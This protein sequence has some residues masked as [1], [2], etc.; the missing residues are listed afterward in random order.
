[1][2]N[3][4]SDILIELSGSFIF[5]IVTIFSLMANSRANLGQHVTAMIIVFCWIALL[6]LCKSSPSVTF[7]PALTLARFLTGREK[8]GRTAALIGVQTGGSLLAALLSRFFIRKLAPLRFSLDRKIITTSDLTPETAAV[9][10]LFL[11]SA[12]LAAAWILYQDHDRTGFSRK[13]LLLLLAGIAWT[14]IVL[15]NAL[16]PLRILVIELVTSRWNQLFGHLS[17]L[18]RNGKVSANYISSIKTLAVDWKNNAMYLTALFS[19]SVVG[20]MLTS[21]KLSRKR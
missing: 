9:I 11:G 12:L 7:N 1:M 21:W 8:P 6:Y 18:L 14:W 10:F 17:Y 3:G 13:S 16:F 19:G 20:A 5:T 2:K 4:K 15:F